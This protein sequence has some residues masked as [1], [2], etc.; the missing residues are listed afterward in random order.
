VSSIVGDLLT[1]GLI[2]ELP[3]VASEG[4]RPP[5]LLVFS[6]DVVYVGC[7]LS[8]SDVIR[9]G[10]VNL[11]DE[12]TDVRSLDCRGA[13][14]DPARVVE[15]VA[16]EVEGWL[17]SRGGAGAIRG[18]GVGA[19]G[20]TDVATGVVKWAPNLEWRDVPLADLLSQRLGVPAV[21][22]NDVNLA[23]M[24][25]VSQGVASQAQHAALVAFHDGVGGAVLIDGRVYRGRGGAGEVGYVVTSWPGADRV[26]AFGASERRLAELLADECEMRGLDVGSMRHEA[27]ALVSLLLTDEGELVLHPKTQQALSE[28]IASMLASIVSLLDPEIVVLSGW[29]EDLPETQLSQIQETLER[30]VPSVPPVRLS[31]LGATATLVG[32]GIAAH[33]TST[34]LTEVIQAR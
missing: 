24:G 6:E 10:F 34:G 17:A 4:G 19:P 14:P 33:R 31:E 16:G 5:R 28:T 8:T 32:A 20:V 27:T 25:E 18:I 11:R 3:T 23:L 7:D 30:L 21:V 22:D 15:L 1:E 12:V 29:I 26:T 2:R 13:A 9:L